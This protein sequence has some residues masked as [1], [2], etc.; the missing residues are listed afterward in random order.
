M[1]RRQFIQTTAGIA[2]VGIAGIGSVS[3]SSGILKN[4]T[5]TSN[6]AI[7][8]TDDDFVIAGQDLTVDGSRGSPI[9]TNAGY[10]G[11]I[12]NN[13]LTVNNV[14]GET[15]GIQIEG[16]DV[17]VNDNRVDGSDQLGDQ[18]LGIGFTDG[19]VGRAKNNTVTCKH[20]VG[21]LAK[22]LGT[23][24]TISRNTVIGV[25]PTTSGWA[26]NGIQV[27]GGA[28]ATVKRNTVN[29]HW[30]DKNDFQSSGIIVFGANDVTAQH[31]GVQDNDMGI[32][33]V[34]ERNKAAHNDVAVTYDSTDTVHYGVFDAFGVDNAIIQNS[35]TA[36]GDNDALVGIIANG[37]NSKLIGN[38][39]SGWQTA[40]SAPGDDTKL[41]D[42]F[43]PDS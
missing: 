20:R 34:G 40:I 24:V 17:D 36:A 19:A 14:G 22:G 12:Y 29:D 28:T 42:P 7:V 9:I 4:A 10:S 33:F 43:D 13:T 16:G 25:G 23:D 11:E 1:N 3:A 6:G 18:F 5:V 26:E 41:P 31:N 27:S 39:I 30:W 15:F 37:D 35:V 2:G 38:R 21:I 8:A 32:A